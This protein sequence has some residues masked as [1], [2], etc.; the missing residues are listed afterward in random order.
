MICPD[1]WKH[2]LDRDLSD[3]RKDGLDRDLSDL[4]KDCL[5][6]DLSDLC[7]NGLDR[8][9]SNLWKDYLDCD[10]CDLC[11]AEFVFRI[12]RCMHESRTRVMMPRY[13][14][15]ISYRHI[16]GAG[17]RTCTTKVKNTN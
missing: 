8:D 1:L 10:L 9:L 3:L 14:N 4:C 6:R 16:P 15:N 17:V 2:Y 7:K 12:G 11:K 5:D 13:D